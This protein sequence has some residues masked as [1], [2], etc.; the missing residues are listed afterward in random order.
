MPQRL[1]QECVYQVIHDRGCASDARFLRCQQWGDGPWVASGADDG[2]LEM[3]E[4]NN[5]NN[6]VTAS[7]SLSDGCSKRRG[8]G[9]LGHDELFWGG[10]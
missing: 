9:I 8:Q 5:N 6:L 4:L 2:S 7:Y 1:H 10:Y 3:L